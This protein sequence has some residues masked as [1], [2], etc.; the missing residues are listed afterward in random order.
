M[1]LTEG[2]IQLTAE[3]PFGPS[4]GNLKTGPFGVALRFAA[5]QSDHHCQVASSSE[6]VSHPRGKKSSLQAA[7]A[8][9]RHCCCSTE[10]RYAFMDTQH[11]GSTGLS[12]NLSQKADS[13][14]AGRSYYAQFLHDLGQLRVVMRP[15][16]G[17][18]FAPESGFLPLNSAHCDTACFCVSASFCMRLQGIC[19]WLEKNAAQLDW[20]IVT[21]AEEIESISANKWADFML[22]GRPAVKEKPF[23][24]IQHCPIQILKESQA[25]GLG[26][27]RVC[28]IEDREGAAAFHPL[29][30]AF[31]EQPAACFSKLGAGEAFGALQ[32][33]R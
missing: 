22:H 9:L 28:A 29:R 23:N 15:A 17:A 31:R 3:P 2:F 30:L 13:L 27:R 24:L 33:L 7:L 20:P 18:D 26:D 21:P 10:D 14:L 16:A 6:S 11:T 4:V 25:E 19:D 32:A 1:L 12:V 8:Q 5:G